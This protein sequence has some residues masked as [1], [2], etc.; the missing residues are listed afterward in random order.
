MGV[1]PRMM[2][3]ENIC[4]PLLENWTR[5]S[6]PLV[7][8]LPNTWEETTWAKSPKNPTKTEAKEKR[9]HSKKPKKRETLGKRKVSSQA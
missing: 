9:P 7:I 1:D 2:L 3:I 8:I 4:H 5:V 6:Y